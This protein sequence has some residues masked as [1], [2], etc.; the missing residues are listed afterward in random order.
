MLLTYRKSIITK[1]LINVKCFFEKIAS[2]FVFVLKK[3]GNEY[4]MRSKRKE[5]RLKSGKALR[6][7]KTSVGSKRVET[8]YVIV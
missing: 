8:F 1:D 5:R 3:L 6:K 2:F 7:I 4:I